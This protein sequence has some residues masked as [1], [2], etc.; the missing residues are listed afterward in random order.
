MTKLLAAVTTA[1]MLTVSTPLATRALAHGNVPDDV[2]RLIHAASTYRGANY[3]TMVAIL[4]CETGGWDRRVINGTKLGRQGERGMA[5][6]HPRG[7][8]P[9]FES[10][11]G[12]YSPSD[13][14]YFLAWAL[15]NGLGRHWSCHP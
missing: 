15:V 9:L 10:R 14:A 11:G 5:Q 12:D 2:D 8:G 7:L 6:I 13:S 4:R 3:W 1:A